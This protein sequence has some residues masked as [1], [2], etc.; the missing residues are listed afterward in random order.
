MT[1]PALTM[2]SLPCVAPWQSSS[3]Q[4]YVKEHSGT[5]LFDGVSFSVERGDVVALSGPNGAAESD[6]APHARGRDERDRRRGGLCEGHADRAPRP[7]TA[8]R[9]RTDA[10]RV[11]ALRGRRPHRPRGRPAHARGCDGERQATTSGDATALRRG[12]DASRARRRLGLARTGGVG[13]ARPRLSGRG[14]RPAA[15]DVLRRRT[16]RA[17]PWAVHSPAIPTCCCSTS[18][19]TISTCGASSGSRTCSARS[20]PRCSSSPTTAGFSKRWRRR[21]SSWRAGD[22]C[23]S[24][25]LGTSGVVRRLRGLSPQGRPSPVTRS[26]SPGWSGSSSASATRS[27]RRGRR[28]RSSRRSRD[29]RRSAPTLLESST[30]SRGARSRSGSTSSS[31]R[32]RD[33]PS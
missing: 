11:R 16:G 6:A 8:A 14:L 25:G 4:A 18:R 29:W 15:R 13:A 3:P 27:R 22:R 23:S 21:C 33:A 9:S 28:R 30:R 31:L 24:A 20:T 5:P 26:T 1:M 7:A 19:R 10:T 2:R 32:D 17:P 12:A